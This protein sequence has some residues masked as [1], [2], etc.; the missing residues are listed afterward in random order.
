MLRQWKEWSAQCI[1]MTVSEAN[2]SGVGIM[3]TRLGTYT[4]HESLLEMGMEAWQEL[5]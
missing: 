2:S 3:S 5:N 4:M 1:K